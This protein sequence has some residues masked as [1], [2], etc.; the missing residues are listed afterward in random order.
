MV[1]RN[2]TL[3]SFYIAYVEHNDVLGAI[4]C[5]RGPTN[6]PVKRKAATLILNNRTIH[7]F[8]ALAFFLYRKCLKNFC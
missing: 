6:P 4:A 7:V 3:N 2:C 1:N 8:F 5:A